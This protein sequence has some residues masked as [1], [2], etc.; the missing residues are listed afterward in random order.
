MSYFWW[1]F[2][3]LLL[4]VRCSWSFMTSDYFSH[5][6]LFNNDDKQ[7][8]TVSAAIKQRNLMIDQE[9]SSQRLRANRYG[10]PR[11]TQQQNQ[12]RQIG[13]IGAGENLPSKSL[14][15]LSST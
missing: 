1:N 4:I 5:S 2:Y 7:D 3:L 10:L 14:I 6:I 8:S 9:Y 12:C 11:C 13:I 15:S